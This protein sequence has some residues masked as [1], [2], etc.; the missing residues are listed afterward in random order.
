MA[1]AIY[2]RS[3]FSAAVFSIAILL[4]AASLAQT[5]DPIIPEPEADLQLAFAA[6]DRAWD[7]STLGFTAAT[8][9]ETPA[10]S[11]G[12]FVP[13]MSN[14]FQTGE[15]IT[16]YAEPVGYGFM[17]TGANYA[18]KLNAGFQL[19]TLTGQILAEQAGFTQFEGSARSKQRQLPTNLS[20]QFEGLPAGTY[21]LKA[22]FNDQY[23]GKEAS[24]SLPFEIEQAQ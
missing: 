23:S 4:P 24:F 1:I 6:L 5:P 15:T 19:L 14:I 3:A 8:F 7:T 20:F 22:D 10:S 17:K 9:A 2:G 12:Q 16:V 11:F 21:I 13:R 18:Y